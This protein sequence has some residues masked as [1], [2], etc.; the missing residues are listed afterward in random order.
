MGAEA[1]LEGGVED[2][3]GDALGAAFVVHGHDDAVHAV[4]DLGGG[5]GVVGD[6]HGLAEHLCFAHGDAF[7]LVAR[8]LHVDVAGF[9]VGVGVVL[10]AEDDDVVLHARF[11]DFGADEGFVGAV[12]D[13]EPL[14]VQAFGADAAADVGQ[15]VVILG[16]GEAT[17]REQ[18]GHNIDEF[19]TDVGQI[20]EVLLV[21]KAAYRE[22]SEAI[23]PPISVLTSSKSAR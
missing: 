9:D 1:L 4:A 22:Q 12:A 14:H 10:L 8:G 7:A 3:V 6:H 18:T 2:E 11:G 19:G 21:R 23:Y 15:V 16:F 17:Y 13:D 20:V 5:G